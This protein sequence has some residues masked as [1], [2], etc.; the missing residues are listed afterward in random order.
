MII[1]YFKKE[2][3]HLMIGKNLYKRIYQYKMKKDQIYE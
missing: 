2:E 1:L 3:E